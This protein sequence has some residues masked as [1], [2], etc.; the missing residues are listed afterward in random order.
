MAEFLYSC[1]R[2]TVER[3]LPREIGCLRRHDQAIHRI[4]DAVEMSDRV[5]G[6]L[7]M[8]IRQNQGTLSSKRRT[9]EFN[10]L[11]DDEAA[12]I[13]DIVRDRFQGLGVPD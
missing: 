13:E 7:V 5:A 3:D 2:R 4:M 11:H 8:Y 9:G 1:V 6:N 12:W 10:Q